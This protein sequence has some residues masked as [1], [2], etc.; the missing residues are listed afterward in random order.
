MLTFSFWS[1]MIANDFMVKLSLVDRCA[2]ETAPAFAGDIKGALE[3]VLYV[4]GP[5]FMKPGRP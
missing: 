5:V 1:G 4:L 2:I 3:L